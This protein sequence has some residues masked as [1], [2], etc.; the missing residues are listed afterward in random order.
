MKVLILSDAN[1]THTRKWVGGLTN[2]GV[3]IVVFS[4]RGPKDHFYESLGV[5]CYSVELFAGKNSSLFSRLVYLFALP[6]LYRVLWKEKPQV[7]HAHY[8]TSYGLLGRLCFYKPFIITVW[9]SD[10]LIF[11]NKNGV[12]KKLLSWILR[13]AETITSASKVMGEKVKALSSAKLEI[14]P[15][16]VDTELFKP[17]YKENHNDFVIGIVKS[18]EPVYGI[19]ILIRAFAQLVDIT[20]RADLKLVIIGDGT[21]RTELMALTASL[22]LEKY[23]NFK[24][25]IANE[26][27]SN[28]YSGFDIACFLSR[29]ESFGVSVVEAASCEIPSVVAPIGGLVEVVTDGETGWV[30]EDLNPAHVAFQLA[31]IIAGKT[32]IRRRGLLA[33]EKV[34]KE[35]EEGLCLKKM[36]NCYQSI[37]TFQN[38]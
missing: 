20:S 7:L 25:R 2:A 16:G 9:G 31:K 15:F 17:N 5:R 13:G 32:E 19:D 27:L 37:L 38:D 34:V 18:L 23:V 29:S 3:E 21:Q 10:V 22:K 6:K 33:R 28:E 14:I 36:L 26:L 30:L 11:P 35:F 24:G 12:L 4:L 8:A 1:S